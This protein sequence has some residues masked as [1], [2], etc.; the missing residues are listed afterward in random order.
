[1]G[2]ER[3]EWDCAEDLGVQPFTATVTAGGGDEFCQMGLFLKC[4][5]GLSAEVRRIV[6]VYMSGPRVPDWMLCLRCFC[7]VCLV[8]RSPEGV[9]GHGR[10]R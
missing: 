10:H 2:K 3:E 5:W 8:V 9:C 1:M 6:D 7:K 4:Q